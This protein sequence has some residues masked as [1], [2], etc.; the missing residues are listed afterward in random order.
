MSQV[1]N[2][3]QAKAFNLPIGTPIPIAVPPGVDP[4]QAVNQFEHSWDPTPLSFYCYWKDPAHNYKAGGHP[5]YDA[6]GNFSYGATGAADGFSLETL[7]GE[8]DRLHGGKNNPIN[9]TDIQSGFDAIHKGGKLST[10]D[11]TPPAHP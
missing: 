3:A 2:S 8:A 11:Y 4:Q 6:Y 5:Q 10:K 1:K 7:Q 9:K